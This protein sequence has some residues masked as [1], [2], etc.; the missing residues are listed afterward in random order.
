MLYTNNEVKHIKIQLFCEIASD[1]S[2][3]L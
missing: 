2:K 1:A 3:D